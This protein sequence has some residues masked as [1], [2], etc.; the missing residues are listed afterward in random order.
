MGSD[1]ADA[2][3]AAGVVA[4]QSWISRLPTVTEVG[5]IVLA[6][7][8]VAGWL[9]PTDVETVGQHNTNSVQEA[10]PLDTKLL[11]ETTLF[12]IEAKEAPAPV[13][14]VKP[15]APSRLSIKLIGTVVADERSAAVV[16]IQPSKEQQLFVVGDSI[17]SGVVLKEVEADAIVID[18][19]GKLEH[20]ELEKNRAFAEMPSLPA[21]RQPP[22]NRLPQ[23]IVPRGV[24][25]SMPSG[26]L[27]NSPRLLSQARIVPHFKAGKSDGFVISGIV[28]D[29]LYEKAGL[30]NGDIIRKVNGTEISAPQQAMQMFQS[31]QSASS[32]DVE[33]Q[34]AGGVQQVH[35]DVQ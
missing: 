9:M 35:Y 4:V 5:L 31:L 25:R 2:E 17:Q 12:G 24:N 6:A 21:A 7:W 20:I 10:S 13:K 29:S 27:R 18:N 32:I 22:V 3:R 19:Q 1:P 26:R 15:V 23:S 8:L 16:V 11:Q 34:R 14:Q 30:Q 33:I 28:P